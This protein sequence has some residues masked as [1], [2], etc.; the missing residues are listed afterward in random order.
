MIDELARLDAKA[1]NELSRKT[2]E[3]G[4]GPEQIVIDFD[5]LNHFESTS[6]SGRPVI[7]LSSRQFYQKL[8][9]SLPL[10]GSKDLSRTFF[11]LHDCIFYEGLDV[12][13]ADF[14][15]SLSLDRSIFYKRTNCESV[16]F[17]GNLLAKDITVWGEL[18]FNTT[19]IHG[20][21]NFAGAC[22]QPD[23]VL[24]FYGAHLY[25]IA[26]FRNL[27]LHGM[28]RFYNLT[29]ERAFVFTDSYSSTVPDFRQASFAEAPDLTGTHIERPVARAFSIDFHRKYARGHGDYHT[30][31]RP[32]IFRLLHFSTALGPG[33]AG[34]FS[35]LRR[36]AISN[37]DVE[38]T[39]AFGSAE[40]VCR[41]FWIDRPHK[42]KGVLPAVSQDG[43]FAKMSSSVPEE[44]KIEPASPSTARFWIGVLF[45]WTSDFG[46]S[47]WKP[48]RLQMVL[49]LVMAIFYREISLD[50]SDDLGQGNVE[51]RGCNEIRDPLLFSTM[52]SLPGF[53]ISGFDD[54]DAVLNCMFGRPPQIPQSVSALLM[55]QNFLSGLF[56]VLLATSIRNAV[57]MK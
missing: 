7:D 57:R 38:R 37:N 47:I 3:T 41:R 43:G 22:V 46:S 18:F 8:V 35:K 48:L 30:D 23:G 25:E 56:L 10:G 54:R 34:M 31:P 42:S 33:Y 44:H 1:W 40:A 9:F 6:V 16:R 53:F 39:L 50:L 28:A 17:R 55:I 49:L 36:M 19:K 2:Q 29:A 27:Q 4:G 52:A 15:P 51:S 45:Q 14:G 20:D 32:W 21:V 5:H 26:I 24:N 12:R 13:S 11:K